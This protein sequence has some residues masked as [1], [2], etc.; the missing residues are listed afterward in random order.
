MFKCYDRDGV[1]TTEDL[2]ALLRADPNYRFVAKTTITDGS[3]VNTSYHVSTVWLGLDHN[4][5]DGPPLIFET[6][7]FGGP[8]DDEDQDDRDEHET[9]RYA[10]Y[11]DAEQGHRRYVALVASWVSD[12]I[13]L[14]PDE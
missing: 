11:S 13:V 8:S 6:M 1:E 4:L 14:G 3:D 12:P 2:V 7:V 9:E 5:D 10:T